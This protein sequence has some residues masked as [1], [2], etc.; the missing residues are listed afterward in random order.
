MLLFDEAGDAIL[1]AHSAQLR[2]KTLL[3]AAQLNRR[4]NRQRQRGC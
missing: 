3:Q 1:H 4:N 2:A